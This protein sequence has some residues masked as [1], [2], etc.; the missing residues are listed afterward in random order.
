LISGATAST[1]TATATGVYSVITTTGSC[2]SLIS[3][4]VTV[5]VNALPLSVI[6]AAG[7][8]SF[9]SGGSVVLYLD[10]MNAEF[11]KDD[12]AW[13]VYITVSNYTDSTTTTLSTAAVLN[14]SDRTAIATGIINT[15][16]S[17]GDGAIGTIKSISGT[18]TSTIEWTANS[19]PANYTI[20]S[21][22]RYTGNINNKRILTARNANPSN[23]WVHGHKNGKRGVVYNGEFKTNS[24]P[25]LNLS[26]N[27]TDW[28]VTCAKNSGSVPNNIYINGVPAGL[29]T[30]GRGALKLAINKFDDNSIINEQSDFALSYVII[31]DSALSD[32]ALKIVS[33]ALMNYLFTGED[34]LFDTSVLTIDDK[35]KVIDAKSNFF[36]EELIRMRE[37]NDMS[38]RYR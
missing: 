31:W 23:D 35:V 10:E 22:T 29:K 12:A 6:T 37:E 27:N 18:T 4:A 19:I 34:L 16:T 15:K 25:E 30:G 9:C 7:P 21:I 8:T 36:K 3:N 17:S 26:G 32:T 38:D 24:S 2:A 13:D 33:D 20:C 11:L 28:V 5:T 1:Y 14:R